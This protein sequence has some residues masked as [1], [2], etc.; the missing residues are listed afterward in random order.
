MLHWNCCF[1]SLSNQVESFKGWKHI[2]YMAAST[3][4]SSGLLTTKDGNPV[5]TEKVVRKLQFAPH[6]PW[7]MWSQVSNA[8]EMQTF[9]PIHPQINPTESQAHLWIYHHVKYSEDITIM[10]IPY[11]D[12]KV[13]EELCK[14]RA[15]ERG[16]MAMWQIAENQRS[17]SSPLWNLTRNLALDRC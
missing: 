6:T 15:R 14:E 16:E 17:F 7:I 9:L 5:L 4:H 1:I 8:K 12:Q 10:T 13:T 11:Q 3:I 2:L